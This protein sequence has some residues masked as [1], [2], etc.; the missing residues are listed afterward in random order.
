MRLP[1]LFTSFALLS[2]ASCAGNK[3]EEK[4]EDG[5]LLPPPTSQ[6]TTEEAKEGSPEETVSQLPK[7]EE[8]DPDLSKVGEWSR[9][10]PVKNLPSQQDLVPSVAPMTEVRGQTSQAS[11]PAQ[12]IIVQP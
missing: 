1:V 4:K 2:L 12:P 11:K 6:P 8:P 7:I 10:S 9:R 5:Q 3:V